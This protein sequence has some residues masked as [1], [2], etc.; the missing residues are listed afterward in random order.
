[1]KKSIGKTPLLKG[2]RKY[3]N[4][5]RKE[6][7]RYLAKTTSPSISISITYI[8]F[9]TKLQKR[10]TIRNGFALI[11]KRYHTIFMD[12]ICAFYGS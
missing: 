12:V 8:V 4:D 11:K 7:Y 5:G 6:K 2:L 1:M 10:Q 3:R 9:L